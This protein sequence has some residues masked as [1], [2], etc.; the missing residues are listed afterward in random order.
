MITAEQRE[1]LNEAFDIL[2]DVYKDMESKRG[3]KAEAKRLDVIINK[4]ENLLWM[5]SKG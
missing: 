5:R 2:L 3:H 4:V 1:R